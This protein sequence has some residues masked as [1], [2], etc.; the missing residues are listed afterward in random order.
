LS[1]RT[2]HCGWKLPGLIVDPVTDHPEC[3]ARKL[4]EV[5]FLVYITSILMQILKN[6]GTN[7]RKRRLIGKLYMDQNV[8]IRVGQGDTRGVKTGRGV[9]QGYFFRRFSSSYVM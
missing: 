4:T 1:D 6:T 5:L 2:K 9:R 8:K 7:W 3:F